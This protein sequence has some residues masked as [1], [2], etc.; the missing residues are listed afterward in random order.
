MRNL[1]MVQLTSHPTLYIPC[2]LY[3]QK[4]D[5]MKPSMRLSAL[6]HTSLSTQVHTEQCPSH[7]VVVQNKGTT[8]LM[9]LDMLL[10]I[11]YYI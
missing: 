1:S 7:G 10:C 3:L 8:S 11:P 9:Q 2:F 5:E 6:D 4:I